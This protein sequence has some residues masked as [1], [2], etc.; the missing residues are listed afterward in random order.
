MAEDEDG[1]DKGGRLSPRGKAFGVAL[2][3]DLLCL[4]LSLIL[5]LVW[6]VV[7]LAIVPYA[8]GA[9][10]GRYVDRRTGM[11]MG[12]LAAAIMTTV[13][14]TIFLLILMRLPGESFDF[15]ETTG[16]SIMAAAYVVSVL[17]GALGGRHGSIA[18]ED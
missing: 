16:L 1:E 5:F 14:V 15:W 6:P 4:P 9:L 8:G 13:L 2:L 17:F 7:I 12:A 11:L 3:V 18:V 10:G